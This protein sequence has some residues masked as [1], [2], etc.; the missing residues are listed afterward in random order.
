VKY[1]G[2][3][4]LIKEMLIGIIP[5]IIVCLLAQVGS[6]GR[7]ERSLEEKKEREK[8]DFLRLKRE[9]RQEFLRQKRER[10]EMLQKSRKLEKKQKRKN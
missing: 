8:K 3:S 4:V 2:D 10:S 7:I 6:K 9:R 5:A 1:V